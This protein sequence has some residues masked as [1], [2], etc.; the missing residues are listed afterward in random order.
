MSDKTVYITYIINSYTLSVYLQLYVHNK[1]YEDM[2]KYIPKE[3]L[4]AE[5]GGDGGTVKEITG[6][7]F[8][9]FSLFMY[10]RWDIVDYLIR[11]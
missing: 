6:N 3:I 7:Q 8:M 1:N 5:Y 2:Y 11:P 10:R 9:K 4:P